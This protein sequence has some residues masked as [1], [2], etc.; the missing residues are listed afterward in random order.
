M[1]R[2]KK[3]RSA[4]PNGSRHLSSEDIRKTREPKEQTKKKGAGLKSGSR[5][6]VALA[7]PATQQQS[8]KK[9]KRIGSKKPIALIVT[10][11]AETATQPRVMPLPKA[12]LAKPKA[13]TLTPEQELA[14]IEN[15]NY[16]QQLLVRVEQD[17]IL[18]GKDAKY[19][20]AKTAR[21]EQLLQQLGLTDDDDSNE[22]IDPLA[23]FES[24]D[25]RK[26]LLGDED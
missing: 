15:D 18:T 20:N 13:E 8:A 7:E 2:Q 11:V 9:D 5:N 16:L 17:E 23:A 26:D 10:D 4:G 19:F 22:Q 3:T 1:T 6:S 12:S 24:K 25:W 14:L 21:L